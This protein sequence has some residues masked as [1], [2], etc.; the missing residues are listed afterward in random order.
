M[1]Q[2]CHQS[3]NCVLVFHDYVYYNISVS[4]FGGPPLILSTLCLM[5]YFP[6]IGPRYPRQLLQVILFLLISMD[7]QLWRSRSR[8]RVQLRPSLNLPLKKDHQ[9]RESMFLTS[10]LY[11]CGCTPESYL[12]SEPTT[13]KSQDSGSRGNFAMSWSC[14]TKWIVGASNQMW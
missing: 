8:R 12:V 2:V 4:F 1:S 5:I 11:P 3:T 7:G 13:R 14:A 6:V 9:P 10:S